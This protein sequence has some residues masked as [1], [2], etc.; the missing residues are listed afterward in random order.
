MSEDIDAHIKGTLNERYDF[1]KKTLTQYHDAIENMAAVLL[2]VE[3]IEGTKVREIIDTF[4]KENNMK[5]R[6][7]HTEKIAAAKERAEAEQKE[8]DEEDASKDA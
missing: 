1:V 8:E 7:A 6:L 3:V 4:E 2:D 5:S